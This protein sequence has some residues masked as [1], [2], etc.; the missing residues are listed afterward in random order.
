MP[1][2]DLTQIEKKLEKRHTWSKSK[3]SNAS[4]SVQGLLENNLINAQTLRQKSGQVLAGIGLAG[5]LLLNSFMPQVGKNVT[6][7]HVTAQALNVA[8][9]L[10]DSL[11]DLVPKQ[12][13]QLSPSQAIEIERVIKEKTGID[14]KA[15][16]DGQQLNHQVGYVGYEQHLLRFPGDSIEL[17]DEELVAGIAPGK[18]AWGYFAPSKEAF[19]TRDYMREK[20]YSNA[21]VHLL[22][23]FMSNV[24]FYRDW[25]KYRKI[26]VVNLNNGKTVVTAMGDVGPAKWTGKQFG[27]SPDTMKALDLH[28]GSRKGLVLYL[29]IDDPGDKIPLGPVTESIKLT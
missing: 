15:N 8:D 1:I 7:Q 6:A 26:L 11:K 20:Y 24:A 28:K 10:K 16:L 2:S 25:Y 14:V 17:H 27:A 18:G 9:S 3:V 22:P 4:L 5:T 29:F 23:D 12:P 19:T 21:Q 13:T